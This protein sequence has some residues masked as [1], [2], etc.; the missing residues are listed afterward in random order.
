MM[1]AAMAHVEPNQKIAPRLGLGDAVSIIVGIVVGTAIFKTP[2]MV[3]QNTPG[4]W[5]ALTAWLVGGLLSLCGAL[6]YAELA[7]TY[8][9]DGGD[10]EYLS[11]GYG[12]WL[13]FFFGWAQLTVIISGNIGIMAYAFAD[14]A[15][16]VLPNLA[17]GIVWLAVL[18]VVALSLANALGTVAGKT[19]QNVLTVAK[20][21]GLAAIVAAGIS[22]AI[23]DQQIPLA[24]PA[25]AVESAATL[26]AFGL[27]M[28]FVL[29]GY[30]GWNHAAF[31]AAEVRDQ[32]RNMPRALLLGLAA[33]TAIYLTINAAYLA[34]L[35]FDGAR[36]SATPAADVLAL[37]IGPSGAAMMGLLVMISA[38][39]AINGMIFTGAR[40]FATWGADFPRLAW[41]G[42]WSSRTRAPVTAI[43]VL[44]IIAVLQML[45][46]GTSTGRRWF[47][48]ALTSVRLS[49]LPWDEYFGG[50]ETLVAG[51]APVF[52][53]FF[54]LTGV[55]LFVLRIRDRGRPR[56]FSTPLF[57]LPPIVFCLTCGY[58]LYASIAYAKWLTVLGVVPLAL[59]VPAYFIA[60]RA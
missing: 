50:F 45:T 57:P 24:A 12:R 10:Y 51:T 7:T 27:A 32:R 46:V 34:V 11:R 39:G 58:M 40:V 26:P 53:L 4:P 22:V 47:D 43:A 55:A 54:L 56:P 25:P 20:I 48:V 35:G 37:A 21:L 9:R 36:G 44:G 60:R 16:R 8:P 42:R 49:P 13:G 15:A 59:G 30:G 17:S 5:A 31:V 19:T 14:Y 38:A 23:G 29:Y 41:L 18:P 1:R 28:V 2:A 6:C 3:F 33:I 52:W